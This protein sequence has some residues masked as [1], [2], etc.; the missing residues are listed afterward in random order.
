MLKDRVAQT[1]TAVGNAS[2]FNITGGAKTGHRTFGAAI[3]YATTTYYAIVHQTSGEWEVGIG[4]V[5]AGAPD[6]LNRTTVLDGSSGA[7]IRVNFSAGTKDVFNSLPGTKAVAFNATSQIVAKN[8]TGALPSIAF[9]G[10]QS[11]GIFRS[12]PETIG[13]AA[14]GAERASLSPVS[15]VVGV[16]AY[17]GLTNLTTTTDTQLTLNTS[18]GEISNRQIIFFQRGGTTKWRI[19]NNISNTNVDRLE[20]YSEAAGYALTFDVS[21]L[22]ATFGAP[23][24]APGIDLNQ[25]AGDSAIVRFISSDV[26]HGMTSLAA[27]DVFGF[28]VKRS[29]PTG[30]LE[31]DT[32]SEDG[33][34]GF[35]VVAN[36]GT[37]AAAKSTSAEGAMSFFGRLKSG[38]NAGALG[39]N[40]N[41]VVFAEGTSTRFILDA[42]GDSHQDVGTAWTNF[43]THDDVALLNLLAAKVSRPSDPLRRSF[44]RWLRQ[45]RSDLEK[46]KLVTFNRDG[47]HFVNMSRL[48]MLHTGALRQIGARIDRVV[49][50]LRD[51]GVDDPRLLL[52]A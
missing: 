23:V 24:T 29:G 38:T 50:V 21:T 2:A 42:D 4:T 35:T 45:N 11:T 14:G 5:T 40:A 28:F 19:G 18:G 25:G 26:A 33:T 47:H 41:I 15:W 27:T 43:D 9:E 44:G 52:T 8:G 12:G 6:V 16:P 22:A 1:S 30:G 37:A 39:A 13:F 51:H 10:D 20:L 3:G 46:A 17:L 7:G 31:L 48:T 34:P 36:V 49:S 32:F